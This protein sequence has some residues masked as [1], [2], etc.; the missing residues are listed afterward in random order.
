MSGELQKNSDFY[1]NFI[2]G[3][4][5]VK[6]FCNH[7]SPSQ[8][9]LWCVCSSCHFQLRICQQ[10]VEPMTRECD[11]IHITALTSALGVPVR[12]EYM[13]RGGDDSTNAHSFPEGS[14]PKFTLLY[15]PGHYDIL[16]R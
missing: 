10:E 11:H 12:I 13:D 8:L 16:Y 7:V 2:E 6:E 4:D 1:I 3:Y 9:T 15:R 5:S 14:S